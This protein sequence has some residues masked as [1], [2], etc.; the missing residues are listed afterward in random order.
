MEM[1]PVESSHIAAIGYD[2]E[3][4]TMRVQFR[5]MGIPGPTYEAA[6]VPAEEHAAFMEAE[7]PGRF[8]HRSFRRNENYEFKP[9]PVDEGEE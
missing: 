3:T 2:P 5:R 8:W 1:K 7:S 9:V 6:N 4:K